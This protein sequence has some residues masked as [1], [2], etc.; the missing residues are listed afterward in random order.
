[1][2]YLVAYAVAESENKESWAW[3]VKNLFECISTSAEHRW[4]II[5][6]QQKG[7]VP[8]LEELYPEGHYRFCF[9]QLYANFKK[10]FRGK[11]LKSCVWKAAKAYTRV[12][13]EKHMT[14]LHSIDSRAYDWM[15]RL[16]PA[17]WC[18]HAFNPITN[19]NRLLNNIS[20]SFNSWVLPVRDRSIITMLGWI[21]RALMVRLHEWGAL[22]E[23][24]YGVR[25]YVVNLENRTCTCFKWDLIRIPCP[26]VVAAIFFQKERVEDYVHVAF[27]KETYLRTYEALINILNGQDQWPKTGSE[28][29]LPSNKLKRP[30]N[31][32]QKQRIRDPDE[33]QNPFKLQR[34]CTSLKCSKCGVHGH[35][36]RTWK[37]PVKG[38]NDGAASSSKNVRSRQT[39]MRFK[40]DAISGEASIG[41]QQ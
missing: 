14:K 8:T 10:E 3:F 27:K 6:N 22:F 16:N 1:M 5:T 38:K 11:E 40:S 29:F 41:N 13:W 15:M 17:Q 36:Q 20:E 12:D 7:P 2:M 33:P 30:T 4:T 25:G 18:R 32:P 19:C 35:N 26:H 37:G 39:F 9:I 28:P 23:V 31:R 24:R 21:K 34:K